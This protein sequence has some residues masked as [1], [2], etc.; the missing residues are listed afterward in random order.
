M[1][2]L[3]APGPCD[4]LANNI[5]IYMYERTTFLY[6]SLFLA[7][8]MAAEALATPDSSYA[9][10]WH[11]I[12]LPGEK[13]K[14]RPEL[15]PPTNADPGRQRAKHE[16]QTPTARSVRGRAKHIEPQRNWVSPATPK[17]LESKHS[18]H[19]CTPPRATK[20]IRKTH[21][22]QL[23]PQAVGEKMRLPS[24]E[25]LRPPRPPGTALKSTGTVVLVR[26]PCPPGRRRRSEQMSL[27]RWL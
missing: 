20:E 12:S 6:V 19:K 18:R 8:A 11:Q 5:P 7:T 23:P 14:Q 2:S 9:A 27:T 25:R 26:L 3:D 17:T 10:S 15:S 13:N 4:W 1:S 22:S 24:L 21:L 16:L